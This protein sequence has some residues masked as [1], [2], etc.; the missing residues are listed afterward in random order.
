MASRISN[1]LRS[2][3]DS[4]KALVAKS[5]FKTGPGE[6]AENDRFLGISVP[7]IRGLAKEFLSANPEDLIP[8]LKS[9][10]HEERFCCLVIW[11]T[12]F[13]KSDIS[14]AQ[15]FGEYLSPTRNSAPLAK[16]LQ[17]PSLWERRIAI[18]S[19]WAWIKSG[20]ISL[21]L[22]FAEA[23]FHDSED[24]IQKATG[25]MLR[26]AAKIDESGVL[27]FIE[28]HG[29]RM[30]RTMLRYAIERIDE[31]KRKEILLKTKT[32]GIVRPPPPCAIL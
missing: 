2:L 5:F 21:T 12:Q 7:Q 32:A 31:K 30:P 23:L 10:W 22:H 28:T 9:R 1:R 11:V 17:S 3:S 20:D 24:L 29:P 14:A 19:T 16:L 6:Y 4:G 25:W 15:L 8:L 13:R 26:E 27:D 18:V